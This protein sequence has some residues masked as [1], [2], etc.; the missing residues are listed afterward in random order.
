MQWFSIVKSV[1]ERLFSFKIIT[2]F[3]KSSTMSMHFA[4]YLYTNI[5]N[6]MKQLNTK[7][8]FFSSTLIKIILHSNKN[9][10]FIFLQFREILQSVLFINM[11]QNTFNKIH[12]VEQI[13]SNKKIPEFF[14]SV[15]FQ[16]AP[17]FSSLHIANHQNPCTRTNL[18]S[19]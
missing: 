6:A 7:E 16:A 1:R 14:S 10:T 3:S 15:F 9:K 13:H 19:L 8:M 18:P 5:L 17:Y 12:Q 2:V 11:D 4:K